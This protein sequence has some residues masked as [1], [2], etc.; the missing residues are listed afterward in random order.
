MAKNDF[1]DLLTSLHS[2]SPVAEMKYLYPKYSAMNFSEN[3]KESNTVQLGK[4]LVFD[5]R[6]FSQ[7][8]Y[9]ISQTLWQ[10][11]SLF[12]IYDTGESKQSYI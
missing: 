5:H 12:I 3:S 2:R 9:G 8:T 7:N 10:V 11:N 6:T 1:Y 4:L